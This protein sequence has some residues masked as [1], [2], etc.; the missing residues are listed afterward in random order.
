MVPMA[1]AGPKGLEVWIVEPDTPGKHPLVLT[2]TASPFFSR[3][4]REIGAGVM[5]PEAIWFARRGWAV[6]IVMRRGFG[7]SGGK[8]PSWGNCNP[9]S[10]AATEKNTPLEFRAVY[11]ALANDAAIDTTRTIAAGWAQAGTISLWFAD[12]APEGL[13]GVIS[14]SGGA[15]GY[16]GLSTLKTCY[17]RTVEPGYRELGTKVRTPTLWIVAQNDKALPVKQATLLADAFKS[18]GGNVQLDILKP[19]KD[20]GI[21]P[22]NHDPDAWTP[23]VEQ[24]LT[25]LGLPA[26]EVIAPEPV[27]PFEFP[28]G[29][30]EGV[31]EPFARFLTL[32]TS[33]AFAM[34]AKGAWGYAFGRPTLEQ[35]KKAALENC[36]SPDCAIVATQSF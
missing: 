32:T 28:K 7:L 13:K 11:E 2:T 5:L 23:L 33:K 22:F 21:W 3:D 4:A 17:E 19:E 1:E 10:L 16:Y 27:T 31:K 18:T 25:S 8:V 24:F 15:G 9:E 36:P 34:N 29:Y 35:A 12:G 6:A 26:A 30:P 14:F 20:L